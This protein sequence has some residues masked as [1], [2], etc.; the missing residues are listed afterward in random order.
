MLKTLFFISIVITAALTVVNMMGTSVTDAIMIMILIDFLS[1]G[2]YMELENKKIATESKDF[3]ASKI[4]GVEKVCNDILTHVKSPNP[5]VEAMIEKQKN[6]IS[7]ILDKITK[8][9][10]ELEERLNLFG[11][12]LSNNLVERK[13]GEAEEEAEVTQVDQGEAKK[14]SY[15]V[16]EIVYISDEE[17]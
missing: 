8:K 14:D 4:E 11:K 13:E 5:G 2:G 12:V 17:Q 1:L 7:Y 15:S 16:G 9:S 3:V 10:L 6:D